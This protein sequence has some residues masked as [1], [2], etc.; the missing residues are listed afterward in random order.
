V[1]VHLNN[2]KGVLVMGT[3]ARINILERET[4]V[5]VP[6]PLRKSQATIATKVAEEGEGKILVSIYKQ[7]DGYP[8]GLGEELKDI[9][10]DLEIVNG[11]GVESEEQANGMG[12]LAA[13]IIKEMKEGIGGVYI[14]H[15]DSEDRGEEYCYNIYALDGVVFVLCV[16]TCHPEP[17]YD[18]P[19]KEWDTSNVYE[20]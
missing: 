12:C 8:G 11:F 6:L 7:F 20:D 9:A 15:P 18:G 17:I 5:S 2:L 10:G 14:I 16:D 3:R 1:I 4:I 19:L 13:Q